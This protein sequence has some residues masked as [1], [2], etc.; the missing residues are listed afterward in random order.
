MVET[1]LHGLRSAAFLA[2]PGWLPA[3]VTGFALPDKFINTRLPLSLARGTTLSFCH[4]KPP[5]P[6]PF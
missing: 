1:I 5:A 2:A 3:W 6:V 4:V